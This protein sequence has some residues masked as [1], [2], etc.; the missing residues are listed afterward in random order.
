MSVTLSHSAGQLFSLSL[1]GQ[2]CG[3]L[4]MT[5]LQCS[6]SWMWP[7][8][9]VH[10]DP[11]ISTVCIWHPNTKLIYFFFTNFLL[12]EQLEM[13]EHLCWQKLSHTVGSGV[14][15]ALWHVGWLTCPVPK[16]FVFCAFSTTWLSALEFVVGAFRPSAAVPAATT[17]TLYPRQIT[18]QDKKQLCQFMS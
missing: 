6:D 15:P 14:Q 18:A 7:P 12:Q 4:L 2:S 8:V 1:Q 9:D 16:I 10:R 3:G 5:E 17:A 11:T 13:Q